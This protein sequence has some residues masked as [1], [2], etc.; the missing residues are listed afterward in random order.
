MFPAFPG[1]HSITSYGVILVLA[2]GVAWWLARRRAAAIGIDPSHVDLALPL[3]FICGALMAG[4]IG[5]LWPGEYQLAGDAY[6]ADGRRRLY[7]VALAGLPVLYAYARIAR[8]SL[9]QLADAVA[10]PALAFMAIVRTGCFLA[11]CCFGDLSGHL[12]RLA[13]IEHPALRVQVATLEIMSAREAPW[14]V[15][16]PAGSFAY[17][18][19]EALGLLEAGAT[20]SLPIHPVQLYETLL[21]VLL[22]LVILR[23]RPRLAY[24]G[25]EA[26]LVL[27]GY[28]SLQF[29][30]EFLRADNALVAGM[31]TLNQLIS[32]GWLLAATALAAFTCRYRTR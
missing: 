20:A 22:Y 7:A 10:L 15:Q 1:V 13:A 32:I 26:L 27:G 17:R 16:F 28:A 6:L 3:A 11:G 14:A 2:C 12:D 4:V 8:V 21:V 23:L 25:S 5:W 30:L 9:R 24:P 19:H 29:L 18:Q 31:L